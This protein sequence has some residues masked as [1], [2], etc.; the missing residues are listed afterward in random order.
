[1]VIALI[2]LLSLFIIFLLFIALYSNP[3]NITSKR[4]KNL[5]LC[6]L[7]CSESSYNIPYSS[8]GF[9]CLTCAVECQIIR[10]SGDRVK[11]QVI[12]INTNLSEVSISGIKELLYLDKKNCRWI[13]KKYI[14]ID[15]IDIRETNFNK[16]MT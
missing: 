2:V 13:N 14:T 9:T 10:Y 4:D 16:L 11:I 1:M 15:S 8:K 6:L 12:D 5:T 3:V 7:I